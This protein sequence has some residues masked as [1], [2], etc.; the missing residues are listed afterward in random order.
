MSIMNV[1]YVNFD[2]KNEETFFKIP[3][4]LNELKFFIYEQWDEVFENNGLII[5][6][7]DNKEIETDDDLNELLNKQNNKKCVVHIK[8]IKN[9]TNLQ[10]FSN[11]Q[12]KDF[13]GL[14]ND[15]NLFSKIQQINEKVESLTKEVEEIKN[16][17]NNYNLTMNNLKNS[18]DD[19]NKKLKKIKQ[20][21]SNE[22]IKLKVSTKEQ[23]I[24]LES[25]LTNKSFY[26]IK[27]K[28]LSTIP[29]KNGF[30]LYYPKNKDSILYID[31][32]NL[33][34]NNQLN[35]KEEREFLIPLIY[36]LD[37]KRYPKKTSFDFRIKNNDS[38]E[39][40]YI[41]TITISK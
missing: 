16:N 13:V 3:Q 5:E 23:D 36:N 30:I 38:F 32:F 37:K 24:K 6:S 4:N 11:I 18:I 28:N 27:I 29:L 14:N 21:K 33:F 34:T 20:K 10:Y 40:T 41:G 31:D 35:P 39:E 17:D 2:E 1:I 19:I 15:N 22:E 26:K 25:L 9:N 8:S 7:D 12:K